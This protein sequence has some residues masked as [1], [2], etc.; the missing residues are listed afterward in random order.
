M[1][2]LRISDMRNFLF[3]AFS[4]VAV[5]HGGMCFADGVYPAIFSR[6]LPTEEFGRYAKVYVSSLKRHGD[7]PDVY[8]VNFPAKCRD[9]SKK[10]DCNN[11]SVFDY[12]S[13][14]V[15]KARFIRKPNNGG[16][17]AILVNNTANHVLDINYSNYAIDIGKED[18]AFDEIY[19]KSNLKIIWAIRLPSGGI[20][21]KEE[22]PA[23]LVPFYLGDK[24]GGMDSYRFKGE[25]PITGFALYSD[26][27]KDLIWRKTA[28]MALDRRAK[29]GRTSK[30]KK[31][32]FCAKNRNQ[33]PLVEA[34]PILL[35]DGTLLILSNNFSFR[36]VA[37]EFA[38]KP[39]ML[40][41]GI[42]II[43]TN[44][45]LNF[46]KAIYSSVRDTDRSELDVDDEEIYL[47]L[48]MQHLFFRKTIFN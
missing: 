43:D 34:E 28:L 39:G 36:M 31:V 6:K 45:V 32:N 5:M 11:I 22:L 19:S 44:V 21:V 17:A 24:N 29:K 42:S 3:F 13:G 18:F 25:A 48:M 38:M 37:N 2:S 8:I 46:K 1:I 9:E 35:P 27:G 16:R 7:L 10:I 12:F 20:L 15:I 40:E 4:L 23:T 26:N 33:L 14:T 30:S 41:H 47:Q